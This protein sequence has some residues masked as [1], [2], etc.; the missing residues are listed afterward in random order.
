MTIPR[1]TFLVQAGAA[2]AALGCPQDPPPEKPKVLAD[3]LERMRTENRPGVALRLTTDA[4]RHVPGHALVYFLNK[5]QADL[6]EMFAEIVF[7]CL[8]S[9][10]IQAHL[11]NADP[12]ATLLAFDE[13]G[14]VDDQMKVDLSEGFERFPAAVL[15]LV[16]GPD[17]ARLKKR[18]EA[19]R[20][21]LGQSFVDALARLG[22]DD[23]E[24]LH[25]V[26]AR[27]VP[28]LVNERK[29]A[30][31]PLRQ[32]ALR[33]LIDKQTPLLPYGIRTEAERGGCGDEC[34][35][36]AANAVSVACGM[37]FPAKNSRSFL[38]YLTQ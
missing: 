12:A 2:A 34:Q 17:D 11:K 27:I 38:R 7:V 22:P 28:L 29:T 20:E 33:R 5:D 23:V 15:K 3:A 21:K 4:R 18:A 32:D 25:R 9:N 8:E 6:R 19:L 37:A 36:R 13:Q 1:R 10:V 31:D 35:E 14:R 26:A 30:T 24:N 16:H